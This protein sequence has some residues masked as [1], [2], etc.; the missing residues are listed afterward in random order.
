MSM[1]ASLQSANKVSQMKTELV[2]TSQ[3]SQTDVTMDEVI[4]PQPAWK[5]F[6]LWQNTSHWIIH[7]RGP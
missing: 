4:W 2:T 6:M 3:S 7:R 5:T 1:L